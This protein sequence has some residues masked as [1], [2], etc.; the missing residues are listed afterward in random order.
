MSQPFNTA[1]IGAAGALQREH[2]CGPCRR[3]NHRFEVSTCLDLV[4]RN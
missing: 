3:S 1:V 2:R 4:G